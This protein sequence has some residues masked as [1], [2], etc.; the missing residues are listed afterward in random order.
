MPSQRTFNQV[1]LGS[2]PSGLTTQNQALNDDLK[3]RENQLEVLRGYF[4]ASG[5]AAQ[6]APNKHAATAAPPDHLLVAQLEAVLPA[7]SSPFPL[8]RREQT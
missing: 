5:T 6:A 8:A 2:S 4:Q 7:L 1:V 3:K